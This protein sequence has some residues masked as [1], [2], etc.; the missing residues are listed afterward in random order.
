MSQPIPAVTAYFDDIRQSLGI[1]VPET[2]GYPA[3][4]NLLHAVG[5]SL[6]P[7]IA[8]GKDAYCRA[9]V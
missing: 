1:G 5:E 2:S 9:G 4:R 6:K 3:L 8:P 7:K